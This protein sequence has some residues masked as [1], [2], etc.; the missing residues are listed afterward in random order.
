MNEITNK[1]VKIAG[2]I[3]QDDNMSAPWDY[4]DTT[5]RVSQILQTFAFVIFSN[6]K[7]LEGAKSNILK[8]DKNIKEEIS[9]YDILMRHPL[10]L[11]WIVQESLGNKMLFRVVKSM[12]WLK[13]T[14]VITGELT[15]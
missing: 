3:G 15:I 2:G 10:I 9:E 5:F 13:K 14:E 7:V 1:P 6:E 8:Q 11:D 4:L 12:K